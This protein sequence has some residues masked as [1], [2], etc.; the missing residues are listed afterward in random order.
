MLTVSTIREAV[1]RMELAERAPE[2]ITWLCIELVRVQ[3]QRD[4]LGQRL[5]WLEDDWWPA[6]AD[7][8]PYDD[9]GPPAPEGWREWAGVQGPLRGDNSRGGSREQT[10]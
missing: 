2:W 4:A 8:W 7:G 10:R 5:W 1:Q 3:K 6:S 9:E